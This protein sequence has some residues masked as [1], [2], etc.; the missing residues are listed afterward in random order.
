M[1]KDGAIR[2]R[3]PFLLTLD[4]YV[5]IWGD[6]LNRKGRGKGE[7]VMARIEDKGAYEVNNVVI[8]TNAQNRANAA[9][10]KFQR[11]RVHKPCPYELLYYPAYMDN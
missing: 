2:R 6:Y 10:R 9:A 5:M 11:E 3:I 8:I 1:T 7:F 4:E